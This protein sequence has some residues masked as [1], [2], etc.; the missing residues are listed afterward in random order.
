MQIDD[1]TTAGPTRQHPMRSLPRRHPR[2]ARSSPSSTLTPPSRRVRVPELA[3]GLLV[4]AVCAF[5]AL[6]WSRSLTATT[7]VLVSRDAIARG[8]VIE[9]GDLVPAEMRGADAVGLVAADR[10]DELVGRVALV[11]LPAGAPVLDAVL[12]DGPP[13][14]VGDALVG[15]ALDRGQ[16]PVDLVVGDVVKVIVVPDP[17][18]LDT[19]GPRM[20]AR[21]A[22]VHGVQ[23]AD[24]FETR[25]VVTLAVAVDDAVDVAAAH[26]VRLARVER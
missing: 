7:A 6:I 8:Q 19:A 2:G 3:V 17:V 5:A 15:V 1:S 4:V 23:P 25:A 24:E 12:A 18:S 16:A 10:A 22:V 20:L 9:S 21:A 26:G 13:L 11:A 14:G